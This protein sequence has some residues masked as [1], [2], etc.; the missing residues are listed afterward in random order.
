LPVDEEGMTTGVTAYES[1]DVGQARAAHA[2]AGAGAP[3]AGA[4]GVAAVAWF[5]E[6]AHHAAVGMALVSMDGY[7]LDVNDELCRLLGRPRHDLVGRTTIEITHPDDQHLASWT[8]PEIAAAESGTHRMEKRYVRPDGGIVDVIRLVKIVPAADGSARCLLTH[9]VDVTQRNARLAGLAELGQRALEETSGDRLI[10][11]AR[12]LVA[13]MLGVSEERAAEALGFTADAVAAMPAED[14]SFVRSVGN[15][16]DAAHARSR[17]EGENRRMAMHDTLTGLANR[18][19][20]SEKVD[21]AL[22]QLVPG[23]EYICVLMLD[24]DGFKRV[25]D[26]LGHARGDALLR[27]VAQ[28]LMGAVRPTDTIARLGGD[29]FAV[30]LA[31]LTGPDEAETVAQRLLDA[32]KAPFTSSGRAV[33]LSA[34]VGVAPA[35]SRSV[36]VANLLADADLAMYE[37]KTSG[38]GRYVVFAPTYRKAAAGRLA[39]E[40]DLRAAVTDGAFQ[41]HF[42]PIVDLVTNRWV[43]TE[44]LL[45]WPHPTRGM[46][47][48]LD[49]IPLAED[50]GLVVPLGKW[51]LE[52]ALEHRRSWAELVN[53]DQTF[54]VAINVSV[55]QL[56]EPGFVDF[57]RAAVE[58]S[59]LPPSSVTLEMTESV[60]MDDSHANLRALEQLRKIGVKIALDDFGT[61]Y[62][63]LS[64]LRRF[65]IDVLKLD[66][67][68]VSGLL[69]SSQDRAITRAVIDLASHL[70]LE[71]V[72]EGIETVEQLDLLRQ[73][74]CRL[75]Q[76]YLLHRPM[77][78]EA[79]TERYPRG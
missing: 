45:R 59:G 10:G 42:Q 1:S 11:D 12:Q 63:S 36:T 15:V 6:A 26:S 20:L 54:E 31:G 2:A 73:L 37:A 14:R 71:L 58:C 4:P 19:L 77:P 69:G 60:F 65:R 67:S 52:K 79:I 51:V 68:F 29:E 27:D 5:A 17:A 72:A 78:V 61:G 21:Q 41:L 62:S 76:G 39:L 24:L 53:A 13:T 23:R 16:L 28:R 9:Y 64:Y 47:P 34:S 48:P 8:F 57:V 43:G 50:T 44:A 33:H 66:R 35:R 3:G 70:D 55:R 30:L 32:L 49:F 40:E 74:G 22:G 7:F 38:K 75:G 18:A 46:V 25:N 56:V